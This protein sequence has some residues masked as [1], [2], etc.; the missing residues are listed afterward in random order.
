MGTHGY[1]LAHFCLDLLWDI[2][3]Y[4]ELNS[5]AVLVLKYRLCRERINDLNMHRLDIEMRN[6]IV[7][8]HT[9]GIRWKA[10]RC[11]PRKGLRV[12]VT[13]S[14][15]LGVNMHVTGSCLDCEIIVPIIRTHA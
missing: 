14:L 15:G 5:K 13:P 4:E 3:L 7:C 12:M 9:E 6:T 11:K 8:G 2:F 10:G 1:G